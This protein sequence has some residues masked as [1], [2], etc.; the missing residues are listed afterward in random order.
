M[1]CFNAQ[2]MIGVNKIEEKN[3]ESKDSALQFVDGPFSTT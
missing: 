3:F 2:I 1:E